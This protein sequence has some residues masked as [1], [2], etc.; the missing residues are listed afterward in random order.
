MTFFDGDAAL[1]VIALDGAG[2]AGFST[3][4]TGFGSRAIRAAYSGDANNAPST[5]NATVVVGMDMT[6]I[7]MLLMDE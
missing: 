1:A 7:L 2:K 6:P 5:A 4:L 3:A